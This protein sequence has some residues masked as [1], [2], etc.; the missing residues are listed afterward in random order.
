MEP[1]RDPEEIEIEYLHRTGAI[2]GRNVLEIGCGSGRLTWRYADMAASAVGVD[3]DSQ[4]LAE[5]ADTRPESAGTRV[6]FAQAQAEDLPLADEA[7]DCAI[8]AWSL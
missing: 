6:D 1:I 8:L 2:H 4:R 3:P 5:A 7:F